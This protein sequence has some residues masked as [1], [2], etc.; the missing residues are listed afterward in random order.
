MEVSSMKTLRRAI[1]S[2]IVIAFLVSQ[3]AAAQQKPSPAEPAGLA[4]EVTYLEGAPPA[5]QPVGKTGGTWYGRFGRVPAWTPPEGS[6]PARA[7][8]IIPRIE[9]GAVRIDVSVY[10][11]AQFFDKELAVASYLLKE[12]DKVTV[13]ELAKFG[14]K[15]FEIAV[16]RVAPGNSALPLIVNN[17]WSL[18]VVSI[19]RLESSLAWYKLSLR[20]LSDKNIA[21]AEIDV[22]AGTK[23]RLS[24]RPRGER[25][26]P[27]VEPGAVLTTKV[28]GVEDVLMKRYSYEPETAPAQSIVIRTL[29]FVDGTFEGDAEPAAQWRAG[30]I[31]YKTQLTRVVALLQEAMDATELKGANL[32]EM[33]ARQ[34]SALSTDVQPSVI[35][36]VSKEFPSLDQKAKTSVGSGIQ[37]SMHS[38]RKELLDEIEEFQKSHNRPTGEKEVRSWLGATAEKYKQW[39]S[40]L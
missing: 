6:L 40:R 29:V 26:A 20:N 37:Y 9:D 1:I 38:V 33:I 21:A 16:V 31:G 22:F 10:V 18:E 17:T 7:V 3:F 8:N 36:E 27:L 23:L 35:D 30:T 25:G 12:S 28:K 19:E 32:V 5:F 2:T 4:L 14:V 34:V 15:P 24:G 11:G 13:E 39:L